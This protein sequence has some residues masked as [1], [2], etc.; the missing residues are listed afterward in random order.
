MEATQIGGK[1]SGHLCNKVN[2]QGFI[3]PIVYRYIMK[4]RKMIHGR[5]GCKVMM[6][7]TGDITLIH[8][9]PDHNTMVACKAIK[10]MMKKQPMFKGVK[11]K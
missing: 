4:D 7:N 1:Q 10:N 9:C 11:K 5:C 6:Y 8:G 2:K 3:Y